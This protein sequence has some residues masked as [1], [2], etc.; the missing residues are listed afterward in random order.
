MIHVTQG[1]LAKLDMDV[2]SNLVMVICIVSSIIGAMVL[3]AFVERPFMRL[4]KR[5]FEAFPTNN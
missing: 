2:D 3:Y 4:R 5:W 1:L